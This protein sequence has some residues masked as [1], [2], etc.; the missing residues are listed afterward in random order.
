MVERWPQ[1]HG[2]VIRMENGNQFKTV[3][4]CSMF[5]PTATTTGTTTIAAAAAT[6]A[7]T[8]NKSTATTVLHKW[9]SKLWRRR[10]RWDQF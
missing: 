9:K 3:Y 8:T 1:S 7:T 6:T 2:D 4:Y 10:F 5:L